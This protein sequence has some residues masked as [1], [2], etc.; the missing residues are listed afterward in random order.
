M[1][2]KSFLILWAIILTLSFILTLSL[3]ACCE[4]VNNSE[5]NV[6]QNVN[7]SETNVPQNVNNSETNVPQKKSSMFVEVE[8]TYPWIIVYHKDTKVMYA[9]SKGSHNKGNF[10]LLVDQDGKPLLYDGGKLQ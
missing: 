9:V 8:S 5:T 4:S 1:Y 6:P 3:Y 7:N 2:K 10:T